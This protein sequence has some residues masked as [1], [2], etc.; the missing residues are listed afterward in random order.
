MSWLHDQTTEMLTR[1]EEA[2]AK[3]A[4]PFFRPFENIGTRVRVGNGSYVNFTSN[5]YLG[6]SQDPRLIEAAVEGTRRYGTGLGSAR[7]Q[8]TTVRHLELERRLARW[9][10]TTGCAV[11]TTGYQTLLASS[12]PSSTTRPAS[13][14]TS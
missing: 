11:F 13:S 14:S 1:I 7:P 8:A 3:N 10:G 12:R 6:L 9:V 4:F 2:K 5:D